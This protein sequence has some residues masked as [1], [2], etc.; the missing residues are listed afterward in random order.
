MIHV[1]I[2]SESLNPRPLFSIFVTSFG[3]PLLLPPGTSFLNKP[4]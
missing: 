4:L 2:L 3:N 1:T